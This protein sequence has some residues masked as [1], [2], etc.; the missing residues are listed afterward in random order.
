MIFCPFYIQVVS[1][2]FLSVMTKY[3]GVACDYSVGTVRIKR[4]R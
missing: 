3:E 4:P 2:D 1:C